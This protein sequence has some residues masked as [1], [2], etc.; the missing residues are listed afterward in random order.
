MSSTKSSVALEL[1]GITK[2]FGNNLAVDNVDFALEQGKI[3][4]GGKPSLVDSPRVGH[5]T[6]ALYACSFVE[7]G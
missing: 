2:V 7:R 4:I 3:L 1:Y 6:L 5:D